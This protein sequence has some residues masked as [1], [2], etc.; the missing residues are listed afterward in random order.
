M[1]AYNY[2]AA[3]K[4]KTKRNNNLYWTLY[5]SATVFS[6]IKVT[7]VYLRNMKHTLSAPVKVHTLHHKLPRL[8]RNF[9]N[10]CF[11]IKILYEFL[12]F[13]IWISWSAPFHFLI[14]FTITLQDD[15][16]MSECIVCIRFNR[17]LLQ[18]D[19]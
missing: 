11:I 12:V 7:E 8:S 19:Y 16:C 9:I 1:I 13:A 5:C 6:S 15:V 14:L 2:M 17:S 18:A 10:F 3:F 4:I